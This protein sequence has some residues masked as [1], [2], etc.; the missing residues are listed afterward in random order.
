MW[1][2]PIPFP[3]PAR[4]IKISH[5][6]LER[7]RWK[8]SRLKDPTMLPLGIDPTCFTTITNR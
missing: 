8:K 2:N 6:Q 1:V 4:L 7:V 5:A 3:F